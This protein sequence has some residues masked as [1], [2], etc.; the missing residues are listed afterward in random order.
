MN[1]VDYSRCLHT[2]DIIIPE[3]KLA[4]NL[5]TGKFCSPK[6]FQHESSSDNTYKS[7]L[8]VPGINHT[9]TS[10]ILGS[11]TNWYHVPDS[12]R[13]MSTGNNPTSDVA[14]SQLRSAT[15]TSDRADQVMNV[16]R[17]SDPVG[18]L[19]ALTDGSADL[20]TRGTPSTCFHISTRKPIRDRDAIAGI[21]LV[22]KAI[23]GDFGRPATFG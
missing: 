13:Q 14:T 16:D 21:C 10:S 6:Y 11:S 22:W 3:Q 9:A 15:A 18:R 4:F 19:M 1:C 2:I 23:F 7:L 12:R 5:I 20:A 8:T 17:W